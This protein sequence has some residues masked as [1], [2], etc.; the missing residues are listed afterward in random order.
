MAPSGLLCGLSRQL[1]E[2]L[3]KTAAKQ[4]RRKTL[5]VLVSGALQSVASLD[6]VFRL[7]L[8]MQ[9]F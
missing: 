2:G 6:V 1:E 3:N 8:T 9:P 5:H 7:P 4:T